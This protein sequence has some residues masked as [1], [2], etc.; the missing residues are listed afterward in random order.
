[1]A[2]IYEEVIR[3]LDELCGDTSQSPEDIASDLRKILEHCEKLLE[4][5]GCNTNNLDTDDEWDDDD[6]WDDY[7]DDNWEEEE[8]D[9]GAF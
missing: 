3:E 7:D 8:D 9:D 6:D 2:N 5:L 1:M 4:G